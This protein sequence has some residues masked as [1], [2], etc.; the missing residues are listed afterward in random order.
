[1][2]TQE[3]LDLLKL[4]KKNLVSLYCNVNHKYN[5]VDFTDKMRTIIDQLDISIHEFNTD[6]K[7]AAT[8]IAIQFMKGNPE[9]GIN[10]VSNFVTQV[11]KAIKSI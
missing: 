10:M 8:Q 4:I 5:D 2:T 9:A 6:G 7:Q 11:M 1:M 3:Q